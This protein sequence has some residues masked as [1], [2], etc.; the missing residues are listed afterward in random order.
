MSLGQRILFAL[1]GLLGKWVIAE[2]HQTGWTEITPKSVTVDIAGGE[3]CTQLPIF[4]NQSPLG[5]I[6]GFKRDN[7]SYG[8]AGWEITLEPE[9]GAPAQHAVTDGT[10]HYLFD[11]LPVGKYMVY[12][13]QKSGWTPVTPTKYEV[14]LKPSDKKDCARVRPFINE[15]V[16]RDIC[17]D[18]YK[19]DKVDKVGLP[20]WPVEAKNLA[21]GAVLDTKT[22]GLGYFR[23][24]NLQPGEYEVRVGDK[25]G[26]VHAGPSSK[27]VTVT[28]PPQDAC[29]SVKFYNRQTESDAPP[30]RPDEPRH[31]GCRAVHT[32]CYGDTLNKIAEWNST[33]IWVILDA[34]D[35][36]NADVIYPGQELCIP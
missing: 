27:I 11:K 29:V 21:T 33:S 5:C 16:P 26:W 14:E 4:R 10:G 8:L 22:D 31:G 25:E 7:L 6:E 12:E 35:I 24:S 15:Q 20:D 2:Q 36:P 17:I 18:G 9:S 3:C 34:N 28:W 32:V 1:A 19:L 13:E 30:P 23:F